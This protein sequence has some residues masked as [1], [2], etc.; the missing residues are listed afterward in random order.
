M[1]VM[2]P[3][4]RVAEY[5]A[6]LQYAQEVFPKERDQGLAEAQRRCRSCIASDLVAQLEDGVCA[7][8]RARNHGS[9]VDG[10]RQESAREEE[11]AA[12]DGLLKAHSEQGTQNH[13]A[14]VMFSGGKDSTYLLHRLRS[15]Y[16]KLR[17]LAVTI[18]SGFA[19]HVALE[20]AEG[21]SRRLDG[22]DWMVYRP[23]KRLFYRAFRYALTHLKEESCYR[24][25]DLL[26]GELTFDIGRN[27][28]AS[29]EIPL[30]VAGTS[31]AQLRLLHNLDTFE[32]P[33]E[34][35]LARRTHTTGGYAVSE[36]SDPKLMGY[37]WDGTRWPSG[38]VPRNILPY[39]AWTY[40]ESF[41]LQEVV[42]LGYLS[43]AH[44]NPLVTNNA[45][46][47]LMVCID[48]AR[49][50]YCGFEPEFALLAREGHASREHWCNVFDAAAHLARTGALLRGSVDDVLQ[51]LDLGREHVGLPCS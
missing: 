8:C 18:D 33:R 41:V 5:H 28:A 17:I 3:Q 10:T 45:L 49:L 46:I 47:P 9:E 21:V 24:T 29:M 11:V 4:E 32:R 51:R 43:A 20:N 44:V 50:G 27:L 37:W 39:H 23:D 42:R 40:D 22:V 31:P 25:I 19:S 16:P 34:V 14:L 35:M 30:F 12:L 15:D 13:D 2:T 36:L 26:D 7:D 38:R 6:F 1:T 48:Y